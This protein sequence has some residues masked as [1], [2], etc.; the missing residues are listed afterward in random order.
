MCTAH[1]FPKKKSTWQLFC[2]ELMCDLQLSTWT[3]RSKDA[4]WLAMW[5]REQMRTKTLSFGSTQNEF[6]T[7]SQN[8]DISIS[9]PWYLVVIRNVHN[10]S[11]FQRQFVKLH[12]CMNW[13]LHCHFDAWEVYPKKINFQSY[14]TNIF[15]IMNVDIM[16]SL[17]EAVP[18][19]SPESTQIYPSNKQT[20][21]Q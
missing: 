18:H 12:D 7:C 1:V 10:L 15:H 20:N 17:P 9:V 11:I 13:R 19:L 5:F 3:V 14:S 2:N 6:S 4:H 16:T 21:G 8:K